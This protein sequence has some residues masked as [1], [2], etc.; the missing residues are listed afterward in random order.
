M[1]DKVGAGVY[2]PDINGCGTPVEMSYHIG[3]HSTVFQAETFAVEK[4]AK[5]LMEAGVENKKIIINCDSQAAIKA[6]DSTIIKSKTTQKARNKLH[7]LGQTNQ[8]LLRWIPAHKGYP[9]QERIR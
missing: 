5:Q 6:V 8:V 3:E 2:I 9:C 7:K 1:N 4:A